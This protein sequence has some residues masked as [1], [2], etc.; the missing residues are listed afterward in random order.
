MFEQRWSGRLS[1][2]LPQYAE[3]TRRFWR[4]QD[5]GFVHSYQVWQAAWTLARQIEKREQRSLDA[6]IIEQLAIFHDIGKFFQELHSLENISLAETV[7]QEYAAAGGVREE[8]RAAVLD[9]IRGSDFYNIRLDPSGH[10]PRT[11]EGEIVR[12][13]DKMQDN[14]VAKVDRYY[15]YGVC[16]RGAPFFLPTVTL[17]QR[18]QFS[19][20]NFLGDQLNVIL[21]LLGL[22][23]TDFTHPLLQET[24][25]RWS[26]PAKQ[27][28][29]QRMLD[30]AREVG[31]PEEHQAQISAIIVWYR[32][33]FDC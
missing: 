8:V 22:R 9:G 25:R 3:Q 4:D 20:E 7:Y 33:T 32:K 15:D 21:S 13:A 28:A 31:E 1:A 17:E 30:L 2:F 26:L 29:V 18:S 23:P 27:A 14:L 24:Y 12:A 6:E 10:P 16:K 19:F 11:L 5:F